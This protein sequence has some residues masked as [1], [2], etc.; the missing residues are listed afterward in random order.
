MSYLNP[1]THIEALTILVIIF[2]LSI[3][4]KFVD[5]EG[6]ATS[7]IV[8]YLIY[9]FGGREY[10]LALITFY[11][12]SVVFTKIR[13]RRVKE[14]ENKEDGVRGWRNVVANGLTVTVAAV[15][16]GLSTDQKI[17]FAAYLG[18]LSSAFADTLATEIGLLHPRMPRLITSMKRVK[19]GTPGAVT[20]LGYLGGLI[21]MTT[22]TL[23]SSTIDKRLSFYE[24]A[25]IVYSSGLIGM[26][27]DSIL[28]ATVQ[29]K[30]RCRVCGKNTESSIH[31][32]STA[33]QIEGVKYINTHTVN[34]IS[35]I[36]GAIIAIT[37]LN[38]LNIIK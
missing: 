28:G 30:Y 31:C 2:L 23:I 12:I 34:L 29:A 37:I 16:S 10:F 14:L 35:T 22:L 3:K 8:G 11:L 32:G 13:V 20:H 38:T 36:I 6:L 9:V 19:P 21:G 5:L 1:F 33:V 7:F 4:F 27:V 15:A 26:T 17:F 18:A 25:I 24:T